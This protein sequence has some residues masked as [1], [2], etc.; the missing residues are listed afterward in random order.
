MTRILLVEGGD[1]S[2]AIAKKILENLDCKVV[3]FDEL[4]AQEP[5]PCFSSAALQK[6]NRPLEQLPTAR[7]D[8][9]AR[10]GRHFGA[11]RKR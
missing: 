8:F 6:L 7:D 3:T 10:K 9:L 4:P 5:P 11:S 2:S 1:L